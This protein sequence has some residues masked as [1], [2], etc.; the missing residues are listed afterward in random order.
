[1]LLPCY[2]CSKLRQKEGEA[3]N[4]ILHNT[5]LNIKFVLKGNLAICRKKNHCGTTLTVPKGIISVFKN[6]VPGHSSPHNKLMH[7]SFSDLH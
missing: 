5:T 4:T 2:S 6:L 1:M 7:Y 3:H